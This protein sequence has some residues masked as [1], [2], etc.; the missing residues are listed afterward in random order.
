[1]KRILVTGATGNVGRHVVS[2]L[3]G[4]NARVAMTRNPDDA[5]LPLRFEEMS[6]DEARRELKA[7]PPIV[8]ML[9]NAWA[10][11]LGQPALITSKVQEITASRPGG[12]GSGSQITPKSSE[13]DPGDVARLHSGGIPHVP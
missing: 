1:M 5:G 6:P 4:A 10:A 8:G 11:A 9:L 3:L 7:P 12:S 2:Q 13:P